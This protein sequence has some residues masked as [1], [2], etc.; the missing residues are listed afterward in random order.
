MKSIGVITQQ[1]S[2]LADFLK[3]NLEQIFSGCAVANNYYLNDQ[4][5]DMFILDDCVLVMS[6]EKAVKARRY[7][8]DI[9][10]I[11]VIQQTTG[12]GRGIG[13]K[14]LAN[15]IGSKDRPI[16]EGEARGML[17]AMKE[18]DLI[19][20]YTGRRGTEMTQRGL[21]FSRWLKNRNCLAK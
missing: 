5:P 19:I 6:S 3:D 8:R 11:I 4:M 7:V 9:K 12:I 10:R 21:A 1:K 2:D 20:Q 18:L 17:S 13:R 15:L 16:S 14:H